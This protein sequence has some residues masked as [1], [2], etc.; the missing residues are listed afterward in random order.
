MRKI[1]NFLGGKENGSDKTGIFDVPS[2]L[3]MLLMVMIT[4][5]SIAFT[6]G[7]YLGSAKDL[8]ARVENVERKQD[9][10]EARLD[11][12]LQ[13]LDSQ[14]SDIRELRACMMGGRT[15]AH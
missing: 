14:G 15:N 11:A 6:A 3:K 5:G 2:L 12:I 13:K 10:V 4:F 7:A 9:R 8:P 1:I